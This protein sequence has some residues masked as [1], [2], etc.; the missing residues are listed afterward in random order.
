[1]TLE[2]LAQLR[3][4]AEASTTKIHE[5]MTGVVEQLRT[6][7]PLSI[8]RNIIQDIWGEGIDG[9][10]LVARL[11]SS[12][13]EENSSMILHAR[14]P[15]EFVKMAY[16]FNKETAGYLES[17]FDYIKK[18]IGEITKILSGYSPDDVIGQEVAKTFRCECLR[19]IEAI[20]YGD[21]QA[22]NVEEMEKWADFQM[23]YLS[24]SVEDGDYL[25]ITDFVPEMEKVGAEVVKCRHK[26]DSDNGYPT[27]SNITF[28]CRLELCT[29]KLTYL[30]CE[31][32]DTLQKIEE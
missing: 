20:R 27:L 29:V 7:V 14:L 2:Q 1:M 8:G 18:A 6:S 25:F 10:K 9:A 13:P 17:I 11:S 12:F 19:F 26:E 3:A 22:T 16:S 24:N 23:A 30:F 4:E 21:F 5:V 31:Y 28:E 32:L 15:E